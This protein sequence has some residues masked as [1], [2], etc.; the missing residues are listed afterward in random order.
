MNLKGLRKNKKGFT[1]IEIIVVIVILAVLMAVAVPSVLKYIDEAN[2]AKYVA[3]ARSIMTA[4]QAELVKDYAVDKVIDTPVNGDADTTITK[5]VDASISEISL[6]K[7]Q[8]YSDEAAK[9]ELTDLS[10]KTP[11]DIKAYIATWTK[12][13]KTIKATIVPNGTI[14]I[15]ETATQQATQQNNGN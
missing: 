2:N 9:S 10:K 6:S 14:S 8:V 15:E 4:A 12:G 3:Q 7:I 11:D 13:S 5:L 1:L